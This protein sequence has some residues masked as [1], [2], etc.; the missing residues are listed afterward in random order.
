[1]IHNIQIIVRATHN[2]VM[3]VNEVEDLHNYQR[4]THSMLC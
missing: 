3:S 4:G 1:M 2:A